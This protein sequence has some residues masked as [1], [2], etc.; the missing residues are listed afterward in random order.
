MAKNVIE[1]GLPCTPSRLVKRTDL[2]AYKVKMSCGG[3]M[4]GSVWNEY[5]E[6]NIPEGEHRIIYVN[7]YAGRSKSINTMFAV[8]SEPVIVESFL[9]DV[10]AHHFYGKEKKGKE[11]YYQEIV[12]AYKPEERINFSNKFV[13]VDDYKNKVDIVSNKIWN[14]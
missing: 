1:I 10:T 6:D 4:G 3:G 13:F 5:L 8:K 2:C 12:I 11:T 7:D 14:E 9:F